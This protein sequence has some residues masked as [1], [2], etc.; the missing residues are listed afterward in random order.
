M[1]KEQAIEVLIQAAQ[2]GQQ[3]G[4]YDLAAAKVIAFA[5]EALTPQK[6]QLTGAMIPEEESPKKKNK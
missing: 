1:N 2:L 4:A 6:E 5:V 3:K